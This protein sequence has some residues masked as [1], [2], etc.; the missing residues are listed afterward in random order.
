MHWVLPLGTM[1][2]Q[3]RHVLEKVGLPSNARLDPD[4]C[5]RYGH[6]RGRRSVRYALLEGRFSTVFIDGI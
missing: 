6:M 5:I 2:S 1:D 4:G 3:E